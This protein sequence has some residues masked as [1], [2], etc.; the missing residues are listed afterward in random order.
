M[1]VKDPSIPVQVPSKRPCCLFSSFFFLSQAYKPGQTLVLPAFM[2]MFSFILIKIAYTH[3]IPVKWYDMI[4]WML[5]RH[6]MKGAAAQWVFVA[7]R[8][9]P[10]QKCCHNW[11]IL[12]TRQQSDL[13][14]KRRDSSKRKKKVC[15]FIWA[16]VCECLSLCMS[17]HACQHKHNCVCVCVCVFTV[18]HRPL[19]DIGHISDLGPVNWRQLVLGQW[20]RLGFGKSWWL[21]ELAQVSRK[22]IQ[23]HLMSPKVTMVCV[24]LCTSVCMCSSMFVCLIL[25]LCSGL[26]QVVRL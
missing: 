11:T 15:V 23:V 24:C 25:L 4:Y 16:C 19:S 21:L 18:C 22:W 10:R 12:C 17:E 26:W 9:T 3:L 14:C 1:K 2:R 8:F 6:H 5:T 13:L 7:S 20:F